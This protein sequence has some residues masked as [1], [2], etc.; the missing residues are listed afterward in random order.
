MRS[1]RP[2]KTIFTRYE[3]CLIKNGF[4]DPIPLHGSAFL[5]M[6]RGGLHIPLV[7]TA[8]VLLALIFLIGVYV[9]QCSE[10]VIIENKPQAAGHTQSR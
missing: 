7:R 10:S 3:C 5:R 4:R 6:T 8:L 1:S 9:A 2:L